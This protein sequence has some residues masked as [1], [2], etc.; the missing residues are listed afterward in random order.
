M[1]LC[2]VLPGPSSSQVGFLIGLRHAG[3][4]GALAAWLGFTLPSA[5]LLYGCARLSAHAQGALALALVHGLKL[6]AVPIVAQALWSMARRLCVD[7]TTA[8][9]ALAAAVLLVLRQDA[10]TQLAALAAG[11]VAGLAFCREAGMPGGGV[12]VPLR[13]ELAWGAA[14]LYG[15]L[16]LG[17]PLLSARFPHGYLALAEAFY[18]AGALVFGGGHVVL[19]L[20]RD[21]LVPQ[22]WISDDSF[23]A[24]YGLAQAVPGPL[25]TVAAYL[26][27]ANSWTANPALGAAVALVFIFLPGL[28]IALAAVVLWSRLA[29]HRALRASLV[30]INAVVVGILAAALYH[31]V[32]TTAVHGGTDLL[33][34]GAALALLALGAPPLVAVA[35]CAGGSVLRV[36][37][38]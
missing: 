25:F 4:A 21:A 12:S 8:A 31:P 19:P 6:V 3:V 37:S 16:L 29:Q 23:L 17:L 7:R 22:G 10:A 18:R 14:A 24:G 28:L 30:G 11:A 26:G 27:A 38:G 32:W 2:Q 9:L 15:V 1:A 5:L 20:L 36:L 33:L 13:R 34:I 35:L